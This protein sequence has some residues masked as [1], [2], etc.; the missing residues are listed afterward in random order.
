M[1]MSLR[2]KKRIRPKTGIHSS[3]FLKRRGPKTPNS[4]F[5]QDGITFYF[6]KGDSLNNRVHLLVIQHQRSTLHQSG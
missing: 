5:I 2:S 3:E 4:S 6:R 1:K